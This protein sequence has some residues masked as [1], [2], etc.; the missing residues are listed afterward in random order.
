MKVQ[1]NTP[2]II[3]RSIFGNGRMI[4]SRQLD[5]IA[6][7]NRKKTRGSKITPTAAFGKR[8]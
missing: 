1:Q 7:K 3:L 2:S 8:Y 5:F 4:Q 6:T